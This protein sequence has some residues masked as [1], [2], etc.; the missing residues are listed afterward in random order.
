MKIKI[1]ETFQYVHEPLRSNEHAIPFLEN[2]QY[3]TDLKNRILFSS[4]GAF[5]ITGL[6]GIGKTTLVTRAIDELTSENSSSTLIIPV[7]L[8]VA[9]EINIT[10]LMYEIIRRFYDS[11]IDNKIIDKVPKYIASRITSAYARTS[12]SFKQSQYESIEKS[13]TT[14]IKPNNISPSL[15]PIKNLI[16][17]LK[18][19]FSFSKRKIS[20]LAKEAS[21]LA[22]SESDVEHDFLRI[23]ELL[24]KG[25]FVPKSFIQSAL[26]TFH[27]K[28]KKPN[29]KLKC[30]FILDELDKLTAKEDGIE[31]LERLLASM[32]NI[33]S[34]TGVCFIFI[35]GTD[36]HDRWQRDIRKGNSL[37]ES[38]FGWHL[39]ISCTWKAVDLLLEK[40]LDTSSFNS[41]EIVFLKGYLQYKGRGI[42][43][44]ILQRF[45]SFI[46]WENGKPYLDFK[47]I[48]IE[49]IKFYTR[50]QNVLKKYYSFVD[51]DSLSQLHIDQDRRRLGNY[52]MTD[53]ILETQG[54]I[55]TIESLDGLVQSTG[56]KSSFPLTKKNKENL[57]EY[58]VKS[59]IVV[60][61]RKKST[62]QT[63]I[64]DVPQAQERLFRLSENIKE[65][66]FTLMRLSE[67]EKQGIARVISDSTIAFE[68]AFPIEIDSTFR[69]NL[70]QR[71][72]I[73][74][75][76]G[77]GGMG[78]V[79]KA[80]DFVLEK[81]IALKLL[82]PHIWP[83]K[84]AIDR[85]LREA[86]IATMLNHTNIVKTLDIVNY[87]DRYI[88]IIMELIKGNNLRT[89]IETN[90]INP[91][92]AVNIA[93][94]MCDALEY[95]SSKGVYRMDIKPSNIILDK[96][97]KPIIIDM[98]LA[99]YKKTDISDTSIT[100]RGAIIGTPKYL[101]P[102]Q[103]EGIALDI[104]TDLYSLGLVIFEMITGKLPWKNNNMAALFQEI[105]KGNIDFSQ[106][107]VSEELKNVI[108]RALRLDLLERF[109]TP[110]DMKE[111]LLETPEAKKIGNNSI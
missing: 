83:N 2:Q 40:L 96:M 58:L 93:I 97:F 15:N 6:R 82:P 75:E 101:A 95:S 56:T 49:K 21:F 106:L 30:I 26:T 1:E 80:Y 59:G 22:Y 81:E 33:L 23:L 70:K 73:L 57:I 88:F 102:E 12:L 66:L 39:Y 43:R 14:S 47:D 7:Y 17:T 62:D 16:E 55:F 24:R 51:E 111:A 78:V 31:S 107:S 32:K 94:Q 37:Y 19:K 44:R 61:V 29:T 10:Q 76:I 64:G 90:K 91:P 87:E 48:D 98:G 53:L 60:T 68:E 25:F 92:S 109:Q 79:F 36:L 28:N 5:L 38:I 46:I 11:L 100:S 72:E 54:K 86:K 45:N 85:F 4:G 103:I 35:G 42:I 67:S 41:N 34:T 108:E 3:V 110:K 69:S 27:L 50:L 77:R 13:R 99:K 74:G 71:Y 18:P 9:R 8:N 20:S 84:I 89:F 104:R 105:M 63:Y 52:Y 65:K